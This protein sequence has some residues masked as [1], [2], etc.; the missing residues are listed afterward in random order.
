MKITLTFKEFIRFE[1]TYFNVINGADAVRNGSVKPSSTTAGKKGGTAKT[2]KHI[3]FWNETYHR[4]FN[5]MIGKKN[6]VTALRNV[7]DTFISMS[8]NKKLPK[9][10]SKKWF[11]EAYPKYK[12]WVADVKKRY[13]KYYK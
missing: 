10:T 2:D 5:E 8:Q 12:N 7:A 4:F 11:N 1:F 9:E 6:N 13:A 3:Q